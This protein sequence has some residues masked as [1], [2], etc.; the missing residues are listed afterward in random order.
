M[1]RR[2]IENKEV[3][4]WE[5]HA[6]IAESMKAL[7][8]AFEAYRKDAWKAGRNLRACRRARTCLQDIKMDAIPAVRKALV[9]LG[10][11]LDSARHGLTVEEWMTVKRTKEAAW[12][13]EA[14]I[15]KT[16][17]RMEEEEGGA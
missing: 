2:K 16:A 11:Q 17:E 7:E 13:A 4:I 8:D 9:E 10:N 15:K 14:K 6:T 5:Y 3:P 1:A 12:R